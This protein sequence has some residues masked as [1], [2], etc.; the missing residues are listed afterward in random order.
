MGLRAGWTASWRRGVVAGLLAAV[1][2]ATPGPALGQAHDDSMLPPGDWSDEQRMAM[3]ELIARTE[4]E[5]PAFGDPEA[6]P[7][8]GFAD[9]GITAPGGYV[10]FINWDW[11][12]DGHILDPS[13]PE[14][15]VFQQHWNEDTQ[16]QEMTLVSAM[17]FLPSETTMETIP[18]ELTWWPGW[19]TH[20]NVCVTDEGTFGGLPTNG[21]CASGHPFDKPPMLHVWIVDNECGHRFGGVDVTGLHCDVHG[22]P[23][24]N[25]PG[26]HDDPGHGDGP[27]QPAPPATPVQNEPHLTG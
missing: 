21:Q 3:H 8:M 4:Q 1:L 6:L 19:H 16:Q 20:S 22:H 10:H 13:H 7:A 17:F 24:G 27:P 25:D 5:L 23:G 9:F 12:D 26:H 2:A 14:S 18:E 15:V 11:M